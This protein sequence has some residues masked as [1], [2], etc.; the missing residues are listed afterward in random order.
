MQDAEVGLKIL[1]TLYLTTLEKVLMVMGE[2]NIGLKTTLIHPII[3][4]ILVDHWRFTV[5]STTEVDIGLIQENF[6]HKTMVDYTFTTQDFLNN[7][8]QGVWKEKSTS[9]YSLL[10]LYKYATKP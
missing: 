1:A 4:V 8:F 3:K 9:K 7:L 6:I 5:M 2:V 10:L